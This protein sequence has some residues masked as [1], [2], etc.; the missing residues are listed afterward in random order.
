VPIFF[1]QQLEPAANQLAAFT[2]E[3][4]ANR[5]AFEERWVKILSDKKI[6]KRTIL[7]NG[8]VAGHIAS[9][10]RVDK[11]EV[12]YWLG[13]EYWNKGIASGALAEFLKEFKKRPLF[14][15]VVKDNV[16]SLRVLQKC[17]FRICGEEKGF[18]HA[19][20]EEVE[21]IILELGQR[22]SQ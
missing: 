21:E 22:A 2:A 12:C 13:Q 5:E 18:A 20:G 4:P 16:A 9:F 8:K 11:P 6:E 17:G 15:R 10:E 7:C 1:E 19:R 3:D 14:A